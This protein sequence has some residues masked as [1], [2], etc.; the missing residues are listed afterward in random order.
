[1]LIITKNYSFSI[2]RVNTFCITIDERKCLKHNSSQ[3]AASYSKGTKKQQ[4]Q[5]H[6]VFIEWKKRRHKKERE[7]KFYAE[8]VQSK[9][10]SSSLANSAANKFGSFGS[11]SSSALLD[12]IPREAI[13]TLNHTDK[14]H[15]QQVSINMQKKQTQK[16]PKHK[17][18]AVD[19]NNNNKHD[20]RSVLCALNY[21]KYSMQFLL[22]WEFLQLSSSSS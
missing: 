8:L 20:C 19:D 5:Q 22:E 2:N 18:R 14:M 16:I 1:M 9:N 13:S 10:S 6:D 12:T 4:Q 7:Q 3:A 11:C 17:R 15:S 21:A